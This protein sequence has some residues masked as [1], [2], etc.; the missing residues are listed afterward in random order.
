MSRVD[1]VA[2]FSSVQHSDSTS[3]HAIFTAKDAIFTAKDGI[4]DYIPH[5]VPF[6]PVPYSING[7]LCLPLS[8]I[9]PISLFPLPLATINLFSC[10]YRSNSEFYLFL[11]FIV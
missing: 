7:S 2:L 10:I 4:I 8:P 5:V 9:L 6:I 3:L 1:T 11:G